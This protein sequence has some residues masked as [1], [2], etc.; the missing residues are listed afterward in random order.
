[1]ATESTETTEALPY[2]RTVACPPAPDYIDAT[3]AQH[4]VGRG[5]H[6]AGVVRGSMFSVDSVAISLRPNNP[7]SLMKEQARDDA[8]ENRVDC[9][10]FLGA[11]TT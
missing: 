9:D 7:H 11:A 8:E 1:M 10:L 2:P 3:T 6:Q 4:H 5:E